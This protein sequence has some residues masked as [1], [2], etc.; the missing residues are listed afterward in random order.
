VYLNSRFGDRCVIVV[1]GPGV[2]IRITMSRRSM[3]S[4]RVEDTSLEKA[5]LAKMHS[6]AIA[7]AMN[8]YL[9]G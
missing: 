9:R 1:V 2:T 4:S 5:A 6:A 3:P 7:P 8:E